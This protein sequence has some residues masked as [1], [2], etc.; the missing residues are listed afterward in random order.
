MSDRLHFVP[1]T[2]RE[3][4]ALDQHLAAF[5][6]RQTG[7]DDIRPLGIAIRDEAGRLVGGLKGLTLLGWLY[8]NVIW[9]EEDRR[10]QGLGTE[11]LRRAESEAVDRGCRAACLTSFS[12]Q[13]PGFYLRQGYRIFGQLENYPEGETKYFLTKPLC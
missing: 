3:L 4:K 1:A 7:I 5:V 13:A 12:F 11:L 9:L 10:G 8:V 6:V 2:E